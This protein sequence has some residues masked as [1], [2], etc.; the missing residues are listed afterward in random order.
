MVCIMGVKKE[1]IF[2]PRV[3]KR[4]GI[5]VHF[6][7]TVGSLATT[8]L[9]LRNNNLK[10]LVLWQ[11]VK[12]ADER[13]GDTTQP[14]AE[15]QKFV[16]GHMNTQ[17]P[18][19]GKELELPLKNTYNARVKAEADRLS[20]VRV[21]QGQE[22]TAYCEQNVVGG[23]LSVRAQCVADYTAARPLVEKTINPDL[24][25]YSFASPSWSPDFA[26]FGIIVS[27]VLVVAL[28]LNIMSRVIARF[29]MQ[30]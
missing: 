9:A 25:K 2:L 27:V 12:D 3:W 22:A 13:A 5:F 17:L 8:A 1:T 29:V 19:L 6:G 10:M 4:T 15:L 16:T 20:Q 23:F 28:V 14:L 18:R 26:G 21:L 24:Y 30:D 7:L 11:A